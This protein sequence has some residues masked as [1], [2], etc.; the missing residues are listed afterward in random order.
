MVYMNIYRLVFI[1]VFLTLFSFSTLNAVEVTDLYIA[2]VP[3]DSQSKKDR[4]IALKQAL[5]LV[6]VKVGGVESVLAHQMISEHL[7]N[8]HSFVTNYRYERL[9]VEQYLRASF[10]QNKINQLFVSA[11]LPIWGSLRPQVILWLVNEQNFERQLIYG[12]DDVPLVKTVNQ[13]IAKRGLP[14]VLPDSAQALGDNVNVSDI[15]GRFKSPIFEASKA[16]LPEAI[17]IIRIS[18]N[19]LLSEEQLNETVNCK[20]VCQSAIAL[21]WSFISTVNNQATQRFSERYYGV[22]E[23]NLLDQALT[24]LTDDIYESYALT[25]N[26]NN[27]FKMNVANVESLA[28][29][30]QLSQFLQQLSSVQSVKLI[31]AEGSMRQFSLTLLGSEQAFLSSLR[32]NKSLKQYIDP[33]DPASRNDIPLFYWER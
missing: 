18:N 12:K 27:E 5:K 13:F 2:K 32:L 30:V 31:K 9:G 4:D 20:N 7:K 33:L 29:F 3:V 15:W 26:E 17:V 21:D 10:D 19:T 25:T 11:N 28:E 22:D 14:I 24:D 16:L 8:Y 23:N 6:L 1:A